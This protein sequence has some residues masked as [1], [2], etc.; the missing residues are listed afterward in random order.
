VSQEP[1]EG[2]ITADEEIV[3][4]QPLQDSLAGIFSLDDF[5]ARARR[6]LSDPALA[7]IA[8]GAADEI[9]LKN[10]TAAFRKRRL[11]PRV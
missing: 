7:Y 5:E 3:L 8:G 10:N 4:E 9:T 6:V 2:P 1:R 11:R